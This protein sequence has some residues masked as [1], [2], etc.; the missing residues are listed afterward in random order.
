MRILAIK[1]QII[2]NRLSKKDKKWF[3]LLSIARLITYIRLSRNFIHLNS[4][5][6]VFKVFKKLKYY[7]IVYLNKS[8]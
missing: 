8:F 1:T 3:P 7:G 6:L 4:T 2:P 5:A